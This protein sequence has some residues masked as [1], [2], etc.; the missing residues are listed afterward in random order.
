MP[1]DE[2]VV[3][4]HLR[5]A[6][7][8]QRPQQLISRLARGRPRTWFIEEPWSTV[9]GWATVRTEEHPAVTR[10]WLDVH[11]EP[12]WHVPSHAPR[13]A[14]YKDELVELLGLAPRRTL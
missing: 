8:W 10:I 4:S 5:W 2:L 12:E 1:P 13:A 11:G 6:Y 3:L 9:V 14:G 7:V